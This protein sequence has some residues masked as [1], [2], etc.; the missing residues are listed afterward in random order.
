[1]A[2]KH[3]LFLALGIVIVISFASFFMIESFFNQTIIGRI[4]LFIFKCKK[5]L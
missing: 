4:L 3:A 2:I 5:H 1:M